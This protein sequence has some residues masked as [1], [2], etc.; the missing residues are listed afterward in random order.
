V[1]LKNK[2]YK[3]FKIIAVL[4]VVFFVS[5]I[6]LWFA[7]PSILKDYI[8]SNDKELINREIT[9]GKIKI[10][11]LKLK[12]NIYNSTIKEVNGKTNFLSFD[13]LSV[14]F[15]L[16]DL[17]KKKVSTDEV[18]LTNLKCYSKWYTI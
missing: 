16:Y 1:A 18:I 11:P 12:A 9:I 4:V 8:E 13:K 6:I 7:L 14:N 3:F 10:N 5:I 2:M 17:L 15:D